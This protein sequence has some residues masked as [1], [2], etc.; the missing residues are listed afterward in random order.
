MTTIRPIHGS[1]LAAIA[2]VVGLASGCGSGGN[3]TPTTPESPKPSATTSTPRSSTTQPEVAEPT[4]DEPAAIEAIPIGQMVTLDGL[5]LTVTN[6]EAV[7]SYPTECGESYTAQDGRSLTAVSI[8]TTNTSKDIAYPDGQY[9][10]QS[11]VT[12]RD[13]DGLQMQFAFPSCKLVG[14]ETFDGLMPGATASRPLLVEGS[15]TDSTAGWIELHPFGGTEPHVIL[16]D[17]DLTLYT[18]E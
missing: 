16:L 1:A 11:S 9:L 4:P 7:D 15:T 5:E 2:L 13:S 8:T 14:E 17:Q 6:V 10:G 3:G 18:E 12:F